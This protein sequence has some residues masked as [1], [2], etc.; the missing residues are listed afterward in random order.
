MTTSQLSLAQLIEQHA[1]ALPASARVHA[2]LQKL[3]GDPLAGLGEIVDLVRMDSGLASGVLRVSNSAAVRRGEP[4]RSVNDAINR[5][6]LR[7]VHRIVGLAVASQFFV[8]ALPLYHLSAQAVLENSLATAAAAAVLARNTGQDER[9]AH[10]LGLL[11]GTGRLVL[12]RAGSAAHV[13][14][15]PPPVPG[16]AFDE[17]AWERDTFGHTNADVAAALLAEW[18]FEPMLCAA[19]RHH[20]DPTRAANAD[21]LL[22]ALLHL[23]CWITS[24]LGKGLPG[25]ARLWSASPAICQLIGLTPETVRDVLPDVRAELNQLGGLLAGR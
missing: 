17:T 9:S 16:V 15:P 20:I 4:L 7:E 21:V 12:Q 6:G 14:A 10:T 13:T 19:V 24:Q 8:S 22:A 3:L 25:E 18:R 2:R 5:V 11:R 1:R 23:A